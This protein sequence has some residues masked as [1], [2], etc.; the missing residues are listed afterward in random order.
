MRVTCPIC[1]SQDFE[2]DRSPH[3]IEAESDLRASFVT[4]RLGQHPHGPEAPDLTSFTHGDP[5]RILS[6]R[7]C[8]MLYREENDP[9]SYEKD[10]CDFDLMNHL[11]PRILNRYRQKE[12]LYRPLFR[13]HAEILE[14]GSFSGAFLQAAEEWGWRPIGLDIGDSTNAFARARGAL[15]RQTSIEDYSPR[16]RRPEGIFIWNCFEQLDDPG[17]ALGRSHQLL[18]RDGLLL[19]R[20][21]NAD[22]YRRQRQRLHHSRPALWSLGYNNLLGF[23]YLHGYTRSTLARLLARHGFAPLNCYPANVQTPPYPDLN[24]RIRAEWNRTLHCG[25]PWIEVIARRIEG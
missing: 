13:Q 17:S 23:P 22:F 25:D 4:R 21:P 3:Q 9:V 6:C 8:G 14:V 16:L 7:Q 20:V 5:A 12:S 2:I 15:V 10:P 11:Y 1:G 18:D 19:L 24:P